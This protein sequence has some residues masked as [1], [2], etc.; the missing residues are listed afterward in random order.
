MPLPTQV[1][2]EGQ[3]A[4][5]GTTH[6]LTGVLSQT[7]PGYCSARPVRVT[8]DPELTGENAGRCGVGNLT[9]RIIGSNMRLGIEMPMDSFHLSASGRETIEACPLCQRCETAVTIFPRSFAG[10]DDAS[11][12]DCRMVVGLE[13][14]QAQEGITTL[15]TRRGTLAAG[16]SLTRNN[17]S[18]RSV[19][20]ARTSKNYQG[21]LT[22][23]EFR[24]PR[25]RYRPAAELGVHQRYTARFA[26]A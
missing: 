20:N 19:T 13:N 17:Q 22:D 2:T 8:T 3:K 4:E 9:N 10:R 5:S 18:Y 15:G 24:Q 14:R 25:V 23:R 7:I 21:N 1:S 26:V 12:K 11:G 6:A 16:I